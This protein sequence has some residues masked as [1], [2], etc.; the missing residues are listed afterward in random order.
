ML[1]S[2]PAYRRTLELYGWADLTGRL[3]ELIRA[4]RWDG[5]AELVTD[6]VLDTLVPTGRYDQIA[7]VLLDR[8]AGLADGVLLGPQ[9][10]PANDADVARLVAELQ[11]R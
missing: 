2:T 8:Y 4:D 1:Y 11:D 10:H 5:L 3:Q 6:E 7:A 9:P